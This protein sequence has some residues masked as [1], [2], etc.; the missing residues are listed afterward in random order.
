MLKADPFRNS[1]N[2]AIVKQDPVLGEYHTKRLKLKREFDLQTHKGGVLGE[3]NSAT[4]ELCL[5]LIILMLFSEIESYWYI[6]I[7]GGAWLSPVVS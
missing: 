4:E 7:V 6:G 5:G 3:P 1:A 2:N